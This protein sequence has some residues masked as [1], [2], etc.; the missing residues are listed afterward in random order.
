MKLAEAMD[1]VKSK[2]A[3]IN[4]PLNTQE[5]EKVKQFRKAKAD[6]EDPMPLI[7]PSLS[8]PISTSE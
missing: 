7:K 6:R 4:D 1:I 5:R 2:A 3:S 8:Q